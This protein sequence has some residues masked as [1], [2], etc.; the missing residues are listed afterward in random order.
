MLALVGYPRTLKTP[1]GIGL[2]V[3]PCEFTPLTL[4]PF[5]LGG[6]LGEPV[7]FKGDKLWPNQSLRPNEGLKSKNGRVQ[8]VLQSDGNCVL[9]GDNKPLWWTGVRPG[10]DQAVMQSDGNFVLYKPGEGAVWASDTAGHPGSYLAL[11]NDANLVLY[12][13]VGGSALWSSETSGFHYYGGPGKAISL[14]DIGDALGDA[15]AIAEI[16]VSFVPVVGQGINAAIAAGAALARGENITDAIVAGAKNALPGGPVAAKAFD[17]AYAAGKALASGGNIG[18]A[19]IAAA[20]AALPEGPAQ[21]AFD[22]G[23]ALAQ[24]QNVQQ[25]LVTATSSLSPEAGRIATA[26]FNDPNLRSLPPAEAAKVLKTDP[27]TVT[28]AVTALNNATPPD[29]AKKRLADWNTLAQLTPDQLA[30]IR[31]YAEAAKKREDAWKALAQLT[32]DQQAQIRKYAEAKAQTKK[33]PALKQAPAPKVASSKPVLVPLKAPMKYAPYPKNMQPR[34][35]VTGVGDLDAP[36]RAMRPH[37]SHP[38]IRH[39]VV[40]HGGRTVPG[41]WGPWWGTPWVPDVNVEVVGAS[42]RTWGSPIEVPPAMLRAAQAALGASKGQPTT[43][44]GPDNVLY[45]FAYEGSNI[46][47]RPCAEMG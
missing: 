37:G 42:C 22:V 21:Q 33:K 40:A 31:M 14:D 19:S 8:V 3:P 13:K 41:W 43:V 5:S 35:G 29:A 6:F 45:L 20:R 32:P 44:R 25:I 47:A 27:A 34:T 7:T 26:I 23:L 1:L 30:K 12:W 36:M 9:Y 10:V 38:G 18:D 39:P 2:G 15:L 11:Q 17:M 4:T 24:G 16:I 46:V 28:Q